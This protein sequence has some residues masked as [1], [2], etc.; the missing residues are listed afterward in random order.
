MT[1]KKFSNFV[2]SSAL[3]MSAGVYA[4]D[5]FD[6]DPVHSQVQ[7]SVNHIGFSNSFGAF[8][9]PSG[10]LVFDDKDPSKSSVS[11]T[12]KLA[13]LDMGDKTWHEHLMGS[14]F[15]DSKKFG[16]ITFTSTSVKMTDATHGTLAGNLSMKGVSKAIEFPFTMNKRGVHPYTMKET[17]GFSAQTTLKR[18]DFGVKGAL[19]A[20]GDD[21]TIRLEVE[22]VRHEAQNAIPQKH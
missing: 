12:L 6:F 18:S 22:A 11:V 4:A 10:N 3:M 5:K 8:R 17:I 2:L 1:M 19:P 7:F 16:T 14:D 15:F 20:V 9:S 13:N 21:V